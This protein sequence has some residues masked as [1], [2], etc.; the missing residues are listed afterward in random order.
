LLEKLWLIAV[1]GS[2]GISLG[3]KNSNH[4]RRVK[5][6]L[7]KF[8]LGKLLPVKLLVSQNRLSNRLATPL[9]P[10]GSFVSGRGNTPV[11]DTKG[12]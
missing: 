6:R 3:Q 8:L 11:P 9:I 1:L 4:L 2:T 10:L 7:V 5:L 12:K